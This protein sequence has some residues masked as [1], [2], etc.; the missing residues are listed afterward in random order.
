[1]WEG[2]GVLPVL[3]VGTVVGG[4]GFGALKFAGL[5]LS[6]V[7]EIDQVELITP[8]N[9][10][11]LPMRTTLVRASDHPITISQNELLRAAGH[12]QK[13]PDE[14]LL[15]ATEGSTKPD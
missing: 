15:R 7:D 6:T 9:T 1:M 12:G 11:L 8:Q 10:H 13:T 5:I 14:E 2:E 3:L 4:V